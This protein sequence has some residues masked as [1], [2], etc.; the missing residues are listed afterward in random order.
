MKKKGKSLSIFIVIIAA[1]LFFAFAGFK[2]F[3]LGGW[4]FKS[5]DK[6]ITR[7]LDLQGGVSV[8]MEIQKDNVTPEELESTKEHLS[9]RV[10]KLGVAETVVATEGTNRVRVDV[11]GK[12]DSKEIVEDLS[13]SGNLV[14]KGPDGQEIL[15]GSDVKKATA[16][17]NTEKGGYEIGLEFNDEGQKKFADAT[18]KYIG[19]KISIYLDDEM[20]QEATVQTQIN[21]GKAAITGNQTLE[22]CKATAGLINSGALPVPVKEVSVTNVGSELGATA[23]PNAM[24][25]GAIGISLVFLLLLILYRYEGLIACITLTLYTILSLLTFIEVGVT[26][27][28]PGIAA[29]LLTIGMA[30]DAHIL[31]YERT[32]EELKRGHSIKSAVKKGA[33]H[34]L[35][36]IIDS[37]M[38][39]MLCALILYFIGSGSVKGFAITLMVGII[40]SLFTALIVNKLLVSLAVE[41]GLLNKYSHFG[42]V[43]KEAEKHV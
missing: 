12:S 27:T 32:K 34:A 10:N 29:F 7:G 22:Q 3:V 30:V 17:A 42:V 25:S 14:F 8:L 19:Q 4:E 23:F 15:S 21:D 38:T 24:K 26:L 1:I 37:N 41:C 36:S 5:F 33:E 20:I 18:A 28:L 35:S 16:Q 6:V 2:G 43:K 31:V 9:L 40:I 39:T 13:K 11:P